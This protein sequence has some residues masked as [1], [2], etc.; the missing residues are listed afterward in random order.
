MSCATESRSVAVG[1]PAGVDELEG[2]SVTCSCCM[3]LPH[4]RQQYPLRAPSSNKLYVAIDAGCCKPS[5]TQVVLSCEMGTSTL[6]TVWISSGYSTSIFTRPQAGAVIQ[7]RAPPVLKSSGMPSASSLLTYAAC[8][9]CFP[10][11]I[12]APTRCLTILCKKALPRSCKSMHLSVS[13]PTYCRDG[14]CTMVVAHF[15][16]RLD[17]HQ[18]ARKDFMHQSETTYLKFYASIL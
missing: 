13:I 14:L 3:F 8:I 18:R 15:R 5:Y 4:T 11:A 7:P 16:V 10:T 9:L 1:I 2:D 17:Q 6:N 12:N